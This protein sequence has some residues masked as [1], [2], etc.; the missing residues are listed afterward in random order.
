MPERNKAIPA[1][2]LYLEKDGKIL[3]SRRCNTGYEDGNYQLPAGHVESGELPS[4]ALVREMEEELGIAVSLEH[5]ALVHVAYRLKHDATDNRADFFFRTATWSGEVENK[6]PEKCSDL[7]W[8]SPDALPENTTPHVRDAIEC[9]L[10]GTF[11][12]ELGIPFL[13]KHGRDF[14][15]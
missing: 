1:A 7:S 6:E 11:Y 13:R 3:L 10:T 9:I 4:E 2:Y 8:F 12:N 5:I 15:P 14:T